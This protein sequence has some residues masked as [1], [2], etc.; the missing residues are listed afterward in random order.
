MKPGLRPSVSKSRISRPSCL[1]I[2]DTSF[3]ISHL[4]LV[5]NLVRSHH[6]W[7]NVV[8][9][10]WATIQELDGLKKSLHAQKGVD[11]G[12]LARNA[13]NWAFGMFTKLDPGVWG[14]TKEECEDS[15]VRGDAAIL[16][17]CRSVHI[18]STPKFSINLKASPKLVASLTNTPIYIS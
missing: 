10:P 2:I 11:L 3:I 17:C 9:M 15:Y 5:D 4:Q 14:Q 7:K 6:R 18:Y 1:L 12:K 16:E 13:I 8:V